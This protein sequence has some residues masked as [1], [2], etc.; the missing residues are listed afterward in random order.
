MTQTPAVVPTLPLSVTCTADARFA[1]TI[2]AL[3][4][5]M[6]AATGEGPAVQRFTDAVTAG[7]AACLEH[8]GDDVGRTLSI[9][10]TASATEWQSQ[11]QWQ[12]PTDE[13]AAVTARLE[14]ALADVADRVE[15]GRTGAD[16][17]C[18]LSCRRG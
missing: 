3:A 9:E 5:R 12:S 10:L 2:T 8:L 4:N 14:A 16:A 1:D 17:F 13:D 6:A 15:C 18:C 7:V 11:L